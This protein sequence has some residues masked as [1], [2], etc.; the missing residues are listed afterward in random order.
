MYFQSVK[1]LPAR[2]INTPPPETTYL[3]SQLTPPAYF[4][5]LLYDMC[6]SCEDRYYVV[7]L[8]Y[9]TIPLNSDA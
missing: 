1:S 7:V 6:L 3:L 5:S 4:T 2:N 8:F 9:D